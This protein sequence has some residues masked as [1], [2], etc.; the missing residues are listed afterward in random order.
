MISMNPYTM[1]FC[2]PYHLWQAID[3]RMDVTGLHS[4]PL[5]ARFFMGSE[6]VTERSR[7]RYEVLISRAG[8]LG[9]HRC[10]IEKTPHN[11]GKIGWI[12]EVEPEAKIIHI[13]RNGISVTR[14]IDQIATKPF[15]RLAFRSKYN[16][17][18][19][20]QDA[21]WKALMTEGPSLGYFGDE[22]GQ[23]RTNAQKGAYEWLVSIGEVDRWRD[24]LGDRLL[25]ITYTQLTA[26]P[27]AICKQISEHI[28][29]PAPPDWLL[30]ARAMISSERVNEDNTLVLPTLMAQKFNEYQERFGFAGRAEI[31]SATN[32]ESNPK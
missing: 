7:R 17:W 10:V 19:G 31:S 9:V 18:W 5:D 24:R 15:Y 12:E 6:D 2:E 4:A 26:D 23:L 22:I 3:S 11:V 28:E 16:Q 21:K 29:I 1:Y 30:Q 8:K 13:V 25:E 20:E 27:A 14:S 32:P